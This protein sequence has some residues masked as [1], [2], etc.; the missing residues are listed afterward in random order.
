M[1]FHN[2]IQGPTI[3]SNVSN[4]KGV[5]LG[6]SSLASP[7]L[8][9]YLMISEHWAD[10]KDYEHILIVLKKIQGQGGNRYVSKALEYEA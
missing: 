5:Y 1:K 4:E 10:K 8:T 3:S 2:R 6:G 9:E 7:T